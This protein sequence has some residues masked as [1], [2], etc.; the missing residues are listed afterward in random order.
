LIVGVGVETNINNSTL[1]S[2]YVN[3]SIA[4]S[5][6]KLNT[7]EKLPPFKLTQQDLEGRFKLNADKRVYI[8]EFKEVEPGI[9]YKG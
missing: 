8:D 7:L 2:S 3:A 9:L 6:F 5:N 1:T 4:N